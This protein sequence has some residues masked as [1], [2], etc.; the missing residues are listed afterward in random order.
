MSAESISLKFKS[1][2]HVPVSEAKVT[3]EE[4]EAAT[5]EIA[6]DIMT[7]QTANAEIYGDYLAAEKRCDKL[8][9]RV[10]ELEAERDSLRLDAIMHIGNGN[11]AVRRIKAQAIR[12]AANKLCA[13]RDGSMHCKLVSFE[14]MNEYANQI[15]GQS[16]G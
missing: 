9:A 12:E 3:R 5:A 10:A 2:N 15:E 13:I 6:A 11:K 7:I 14:E 16:N 1:G 4:W 8:Q